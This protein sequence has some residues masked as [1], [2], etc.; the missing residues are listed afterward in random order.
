MT[1]NR[2]IRRRPAESLD[3]D[4]NTLLH[5]I[6]DE[7]VSPALRAQ[8]LKLQNAMEAAGKLTRDAAN[9]S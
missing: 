7:P 2:N 5:Q 4:L 1:E 6:A 9:D 3:Q 8:A